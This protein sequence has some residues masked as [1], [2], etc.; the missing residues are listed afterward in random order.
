LP[1]KKR[2]QI[3]GGKV[4]AQADRDS[5]DLFFIETGFEE[6]DVVHNFWRLKIASDEDW[7]KYHEAEYQAE[8]QYYKE[9]TAGVMDLDELEYFDSDTE[10][11]PEAKSSEETKTEES[12]E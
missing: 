10:E 1:E 5:W 9:L 3:E 4:F 11:T 8:R 12:V 6:R 7:V 2:T